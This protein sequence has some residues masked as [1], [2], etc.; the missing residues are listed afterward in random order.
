MVINDRFIEVRLKARDKV[1]RVFG[2]LIAELLEL[3]LTQGG[4]CTNKD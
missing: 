3:C 4:N 1:A 2:Q